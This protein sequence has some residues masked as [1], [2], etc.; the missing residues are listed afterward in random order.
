MR[1]SSITFGSATP[2]SD[3]E[4]Q[5]FFKDSDKNYLADLYVKTFQGALT[6]SGI[7][8]EQFRQGRFFTRTGKSKVSGVSSHGS[9]REMMR[10]LLYLEQGKIVDPFSSR[11]IKRL[12]YMTERRIRYASSPALTDAAVYFKSGSLY[13]CQ[14]EEGYECKK[15]QGNKMNFMNSIAIVESPASPRKLFYIVTLNSN[16]LK[17]NSAVD[18]QTLAT[19]IHRLIEKAHA[20]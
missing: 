20:Q 14:P 12:L 3:E 10:F 6:R 11:E 1:C 4:G 7:D 15:Y 5:A 8:T 19:R 17:K 9:S 2:V 18:H 13:A 16:V